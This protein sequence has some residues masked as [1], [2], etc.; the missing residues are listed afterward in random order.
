MNTNLKNEPN[1]EAILRHLELQGTLE[2]ARSF[3]REHNLPFSAGSWEEMRNKRIKPAI[4]SNSITIS[5]LLGLLAEVEEHGSQHVFLYSLAQNQSITHLFDHSALQKLLSSEEKFPLLNEQSFVDMPST[6]RI[7]EVRQEMHGDIRCLVFKIVERRFLRENSEEHYETGKIVITFEETPYRA[8]NIVRIWESGFCEVRIHSHQEALSYGGEAQGVLRSLEPLF[9]Q[10]TWREYDLAN[11]RNGLFDPQRRDENKLLFSLKNANHRNNV[12]S[13]LAVSTVRT[14]ASIYDDD[15]TVA[16][17]DT[18]H[19]NKD[20]SGAY[21][22]RVNIA[23]RAAA[24]NG[25]LARDINLIMHGENN[26]FTLTSR[27]TRSEY[28]YT[29]S[30]IQSQNV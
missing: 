21:C 13:K 27:I 4:Q 5:D 14:E 17:L 12:G 24:S 29:L 25:L 10:F 18:F 28:E 1:I 23:V 19:L 26:E 2:Q 3:L 7:S 8:V 22:D 11:A 30:L 16:S 20:A 15:S 9:T 6:P